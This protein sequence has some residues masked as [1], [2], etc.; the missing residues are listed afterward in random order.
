M[1]RLKLSIA[2]T[3]YDHF[4]DFRLDSTGQITDTHYRLASRHDLDV[5]NNPDN[6]SADRPLF[7]FLFNRRDYDGTPQP[8]GRPSQDVYRRP[9][10]Q[11]PFFFPFFGR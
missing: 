6:T 3:D 9:Q 10:Q 1:A 8:Y 7:D 4:R 5:A 2:T 11:Q